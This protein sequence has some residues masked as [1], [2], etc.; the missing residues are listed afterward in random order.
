MN[1]KAI[2]VLLAVVALFISACAAG[3]N[4]ADFQQK[5][6]DANSN[7]KSYSLDMDMN[8]KMDLTG[9]GMSLQMNTVTQATG[10]VDTANKKMHMNMNMK[11]DAF[12]QKTETNTEMYSVGD[13]VYTSTA[14]QWFKAPF[15]QKTWDSQ[16]SIKSQL[17]LLKSGTIEQLPDETIDGKAYYVVKVKP[18]MKKLAEQMMQGG[19]SGMPADLDFGKV[20]KNF[21][22]MLWVNKDTFV[23]ER[24]KT[25]MKMEMTAADLG[26]EGEGNMAFDIMSDAKMSNI[27]APV[28][29][30]LPAAAANAV[31]ASSMMGGATGNA[32]AADAFA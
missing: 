6:I 1:K 9:Q 2:L 20:I 16:D 11:A 3:P 25:T 21:D 14:G 4:S 22:V 5:L 29:I 13:S 30:T 10:Q 17:D 18:D 15:D 28:D 27:D 7:I 12:G 23:M 8:M 24:S 19:G 31:D 32:V 26:K